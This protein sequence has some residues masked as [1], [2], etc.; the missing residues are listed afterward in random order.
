MKLS[1]G[2][3]PECASNKTSKEKI[4][5]SDTGDIVCDTCGYTGHWKEF[6]LRVVVDIFSGLGKD[7][8]PMKNLQNEV[9]KHESHVSEPR[10]VNS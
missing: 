5:G 7:S 2:V 3:C 8:V 4:M 6:Q 10:S 9:Q 1:D